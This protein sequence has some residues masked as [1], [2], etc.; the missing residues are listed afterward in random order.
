MEELILGLTFQPQSTEPTNNEKTVVQPLGVETP[1][2]GFF[3]QYSEFQSQPLNSPVA[4]FNRLCKEYEWERGDPEREAAR[5]DFNFAIKREFDDLYGSDE[6]DVDNWQKLCRVLKID[7]V[8]D[9]LGGCRAVVVTKHVNL[10]D[11]IE[12]N[13]K[14]VRIFETEEQL[15]Q[16]TRETCKFFPKE[17]AKDG[18][19]LRALRRHILS[20][21]AGAMRLRTAGRRGRRNKGN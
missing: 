1:L 17:D 6:N 5:D 15:S 8:P 7:P 3:S 10:V 21:G 4:E 18:G 11:L 20:P 9:T 14:E 16:Y 12:G 13:R 2:E 19:V